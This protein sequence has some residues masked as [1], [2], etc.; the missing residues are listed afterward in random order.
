MLIEHFKASKMEYI[1]VL[2]YMQGI[3]DCGKRQSDLWVD[4]FGAGSTDL[5]TLHTRHKE[6]LKYRYKYHTHAVPRETLNLLHF[7]FIIL[8]F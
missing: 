1:Y 6:N 7:F 8:D 2:V 5:L 3:H 4:G